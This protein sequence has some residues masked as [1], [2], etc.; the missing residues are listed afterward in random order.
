MQ[1]AV[2]STVAIAALVPLILWRTYVRF[3]RASGRQRLS[4]Y[5]GPISLTIYSLLIGLVALANLSYPTRLFAFAVA[6]A[7]GAGLAAYALGRTHFEPTRKGL[8]YTPHSHIGLSLAVLFVVRMVYRLVEVYA[9]GTSQPGNFGEFAQSPLTI[10]AFGLMA[11]YYWWYMIGLVRW[12]R[13]V[14]R[15]KREREVGRGDA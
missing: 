7:A 6:L 13:G 12:R 3:R 10:G 2:G 9:A 15:A 4:R 5:R 11:G 14:L 8:Y 1:P